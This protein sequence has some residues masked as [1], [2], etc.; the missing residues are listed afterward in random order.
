M[1][2]QSIVALDLSCEM[3]HET[4]S[5]YTVHHAESPAN[6]W[7][8]V[9]TPSMALST[10][11]IPSSSSLLL[12]PLEQDA[13]YFFE[14]RFA[15]AGP[16]TFI[17][18]PFAVLLRYAVEDSMLMHLTLA[19]CLSRM[20]TQSEL[21]RS[22]LISSS[23]MHASRG[24]HELSTRLAQGDTDPCKVAM[25]V[26]LLQRTYSAIWDDQTRSLLAQLSDSMAAYIQRYRLLNLYRTSAGDDDFDDGDVALDTA[27]DTM[28]SS[29]PRENAILARF[30]MLTAYEDIDSEHC[31]V[32][33]AI[34]DLIMTHTPT[35][36][37]LFRAGHDC[38]RRFF[39]EEY[40]P[41]EH[42]D[43]IQRFR[44]LEFHFK[45]NVDLHRAYKFCQRQD[46]YNSLRRLERH[47]V[48]LGQQYSDVVSLADCT[49]KNKLTTICLYVTAHYH[50]VLVVVRGW[51]LWEN[52]DDDVIARLRDSRQNLQR[53][54]RK[55]VKEHP[56]AFSWRNQWP[57]YIMMTRSGNASHTLL[58]SD[59]FEMRYVVSL[60]QAAL[61]LN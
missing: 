46:S 60:E 15:N 30:L 25:A 55:M 51:L 6:V 21:V 54:G 38:Q 22:T 49:L 50:A 27:P 10:W 24:K 18:S 11:H 31:G 36:A 40:P 59:Q 52:P 42:M 23:R 45:V 13:I 58:P 14:Q 37:A 57:L 33:G 9:A 4:D 19:S 56:E 39:G 28:P 2:E 20:A 34:A 48:N 53:C 43:D 35:A 44:P 41:E 29:S 16:K 1:I 47:L 8:N 26:F 32:G 12:G 7:A 17:W 3:L 61:R 5:V